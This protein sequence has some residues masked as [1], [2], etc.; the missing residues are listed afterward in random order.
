MKEYKG[1]LPEIEVLSLTQDA[2]KVLPGSV[3]VAIRGTQADG[4]DF[5]PQA[6]AQGAV[7][8]VVENLAK[9]PAGYQGVVLQCKNSRV[10]LDQMAAL[11]FREPSKELF[12]YGV[13]GTNGKTSITYMLEF[14]LNEKKVP[15][16]VLGTI[17]HHLGEKVWPTSMT[18][19]DPILLQQR[20]REM[21]EEGA[22]AVAME[23]SSHALHQHRVD[24][25]HFNSVIFTNL[26]RDHLDYHKD[27][28][29]Y[30]NSKQRL[31][32]ELLWSSLKY[33]LFA[34]VNVDDPWGVRLRLASNAVLWTYGQK[35]TADFCFRIDKVDFARTDFSLKTPFGSYNSYIPMCGEH[36][37]ANAVAVIAAAAS[38]GI[39]IR[40]ALEALKNF[41]GVPGRLQFVPNRKNLNVFVDYA[42]SPDA[43]ENVLS[44]L[45]KVRSQAGSQGKIWTVFGCGGDRDKGKRPLM[46]QVAA[47]L[48]DYVM[49][50]SDNPRTENPEQIIKDILQGFSLELSQE[51]ILPA[52]VDR[53][54]AIEQV[55]KAARPEDIILIAGKGHEDYQIIGHEKTP[56][57]DFKIAQSALL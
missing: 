28:K 52:Q 33:P 48:S 9:V 24:Q 49:V 32:T 51:K 10:L 44:S 1:S 21:R 17:N 27:M 39:R 41:T 29:D 23:V 6:C 46:A 30:L 8:I 56:F 25:V 7:A 37:V 36:N 57:D 45:Q 20:L 12:T 50:T 19:P 34:I 54:Q 3:F 40:V 35:S 42:H 31:F 26:T 13:T 14:I 11:F 18:T 5:L 15:C 55:I 53:K 2:R 22:R 43:L 4:H 16:G 38:A 47:R